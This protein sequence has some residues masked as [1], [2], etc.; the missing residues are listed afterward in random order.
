MVDFFPKSYKKILPVSLYEMFDIKTKINKQ[1]SLNNCLDNLSPLPIFYFGADYPS[2]LRTALDGKF[3]SLGLREMEEDLIKTFSD[4]SL[5]STWREGTIKSSFNYL[6][7]DS[8]VTQ[9]LPNRADNL[10]NIFKH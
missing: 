10:G 3:D 7:L 2:V 9:D 5:S 8:R 4:K 6:L 1:F